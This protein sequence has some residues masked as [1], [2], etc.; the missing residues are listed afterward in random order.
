MSKKIL[1]YIFIILFVIVIFLLQ[2]YLID[3]RTLFG[4][5]PNLILIS[6]ITISLW[7]GL[8]VG[9]FYSAIIGIMADLIFGSA[10]GQ[11]LICYAVTGTIIGFLNYNYRKENKNSLLY[12]TVLATAI[13]EFTQS[14][15]Y[16]FEMN[17]FVNFFYLLKQIVIS[18]LLNICIA[19]IIYGLLYKISEKIDDNL[20]EKI[21]Y[22]SL[23]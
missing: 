21:N 19:Y 6:V 2:I 5:K 10:N 17:S 9:A 3:S 18:S 16:I 7:Y 14:V 8:Y 4:V 20:N 13:F 15:I 22:G 12:V 23:R 1:T 11:F